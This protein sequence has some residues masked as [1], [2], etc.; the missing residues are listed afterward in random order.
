MTKK[1]A[2]INDLSG[3]GRCSL[4]AS[5]PVISTIGIQTCPL[6][7]AILS[8][9]T[10]FHD[11]YYD[12]YT[13]R[14]DSFTA[15]WKKMNVSFDGIYCGYLSGPNQIAKA[16]TFLDTF[17]TKDTLCL[18][19][20]ILGDGGTPYPFY[21]V[22][23][24][25]EMKTLTTRSNLITPNLTELCLLANVDYRTITAPQKEAVFLKNIRIV[26]ENLLEQAKCPQTILVTGI[27]QNKKNTVTVTNL[28][29]SATECAQTETLYTGISFSGTG[30]LF[31]SAVFGY[32][33][34]GLPL[35]EAMDK[36]TA[37]L[38]P[39]IESATLEGTHR[40]HG[41]PFEQYLSRLL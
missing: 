39:A 5:I 8:A 27:L 24:L 10:G 17:Q 1:V 6:P 15:S 36:A 35:Q 33:V 37:F 28:A 38:L 7:T 13:D 21:S 34:K 41:V 20:P 14:M 18:T 19:D 30:D 40:N 2:L 9:Q 22:K 23:L 16:R 3:F 12:D 26:C 25:Q 11:Y 32:L 29:V 31:A 4:T